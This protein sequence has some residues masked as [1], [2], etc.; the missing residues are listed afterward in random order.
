MQD[1]PEDK[2][3]NVIEKWIVSISL[4]GTLRRWSLDG[5]VEEKQ[6]DE[7]D[8]SHDDGTLNSSQTN[9]DVESGGKKQ[10]MTAT[11]E[12]DRELAELMA[13]MEDD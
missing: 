13:D 12:E 3:A 6:S 10:V 2:V 9:R 5:S 8:E 7:V 4:D 11:E 1:K